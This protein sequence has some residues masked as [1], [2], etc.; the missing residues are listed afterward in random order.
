MWRRGCRKK[1]KLRRRFGVLENS[2]AR[3]W[4]ASPLWAVGLAALRAYYN[5][6]YSVLCLIFNP[7][8]SICVRLLV[9]DAHAMH[10]GRIRNTKRNCLVRTFTQEGTAYEQTKTKECSADPRPPTHQ[11]KSN[12]APE[13]TAY[14]SLVLRV[15]A[16]EYRGNLSRFTQVLVLGK[17]S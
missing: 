6:I 12:P 9:F 2:E 5:L 10:A 11:L 8:F 7:H 14:R 3:V 1:K 16:S 13:L 15:S 17:R 4:Y